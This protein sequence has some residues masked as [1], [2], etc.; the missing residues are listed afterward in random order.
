MQ[1][2]FEKTKLL[3]ENYCKYYKEVIKYKSNCKI[4]DDMKIHITFK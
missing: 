1:I 2:S 4:A 3:E